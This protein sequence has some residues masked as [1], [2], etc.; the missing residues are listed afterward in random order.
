MKRTH[1]LKSMSI[2]SGALAARSVLAKASPETKQPNVVLLVT[3][4][5]GYGDLSA[6]GNPIIQTPNMDRL[7]AGSVRFNSFH[8]DPTCAP[9]RGALMTGKYAHHVRVWHTIAGGNSLRKT[10]MTMAEVFK[11]SGYST[12]LFGKWHLGTNYPYRPMD[13]GF[14]AWLGSGGGGPGTTDDYFTND[15]V[16]DHYWRNGEREFI[17][18]YNP[19]VFYDAAV[20]HI[21]QHAHDLLPI[22]MYVPTYAPHGPHSIPDPERTKKYTTAGY[23][24][25]VASQYAMIEH[26]DAGIGRLLDTLEQTGVA[27]DTIVIFMSDNG[28]TEGRSVFNAGMR[29]GKGSEYDGGHRV[30][31]FF[32]WP[33]GKLAHGADVA[34][35][36]AHIDVL[37]TLIDLCGLTPPRQVKF[38]GRSFKKQLFAPTISLPPRVVCV[39]TQRTM[40]PEKW[41]KTAAMRGTWRLVNETELYDIAVD[42]GQKKNIIK[43]HPEIARELSK[44]YDAYWTKVSPGDR[45]PTRPIIG[46]SH[47]P[48]TFLS[49]E[50]WYSDNTPPWNHAQAALGKKGNGLWHARVSRAGTYHIEARRWPR[51][52]RAPMRGVPQLNKTVDAWVGAKPIEG[53]LYGNRFKA[54]PVAAVEI[55]VNGVVVATRSVSATDESARFELPLAAGDAS[56]QVVMLNANQKLISGAYYVYI[57]RKD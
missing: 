40:L 57:R 38:D 27:D 16:N 48:E 11:S 45:D 56:L 51:E 5:Q 17:E 26:V 28:A 25:K 36:N 2:G 52:A 6:H 46:T 12:A 41:H 23:N 20:S 53:L 30:P 19:S 31:F 15:R 10:E 37:P 32:R 49:S 18:G 43:E 35:L 3:D 44:A 8:V 50:D 14:E 22:F 47:D 29:E 21:K 1:F 33:N 55:R 34:D 7:H 42:P 54:L 13:R 4:D 24:I 9:T 39:E